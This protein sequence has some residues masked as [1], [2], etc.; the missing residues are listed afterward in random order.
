L[1][2]GQPFRIDNIRSKRPKPGL[3][4]QH[5]ACVHA[6]V[7]VGGGLE[8]THAV[9]TGGRVVQVGETSLTFTPGKV[10]AGDYDLPSVRPAVACWYCKRC[11]GHWCWRTVYLPL[12]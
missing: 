1:I 12:S 9:G 3:M 8:H 2:T 5:L 6:A 11:C 7:A 4:R 10:C